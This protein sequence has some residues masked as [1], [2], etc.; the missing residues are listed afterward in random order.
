MLTK[1]LVCR[2]CRQSNALGTPRCTACGTQLSQSEITVTSIPADTTVTSVPAD[3]EHTVTSIPVDGTAAWPKATRF[4]IAAVSMGSMLVEG[5]VV[6]ERYEILKLL[7]EGGMGAVYKAHDRELDRVVSLKVI[8]PEL[9][10]HPSILQ[11]FKQEIVLARKITHRN[12]IRIFDLG[13]ATGLRFITMEF[14]EG[15]DLSAILDERKKY[16][17]EEAV[18]ILRQI[19]AALE[20][21]HAEGVVHR[22]LKPQ[23]IMIEA[24][25]R[26]CVMDFGLARSLEAGGFTQV[27]AIMGTPTYMSPEQAKGEA[28]DERSDLF[29]LGLIAYQLLIGK[30]P[31]KGDTPLSSMLL[32]TQ[33]PP[34][35]PIEIDP[36][37]PQQLSDIVMK[38]IAIPLGDRY[39][40]A[41]ELQRDLQEWQE[42]RLSRT[43][44]MPPAPPEKP[45]L[46]VKKWLGLGAAA[47]VLLGIGVFGGNWFSGGSAPPAPTTP[48]T[49]IISDFNNHTGD[50]VFAG[51]LEST[52]KLALEG[53]SFISAYDRSRIRELGIPA[54]DGSLDA[55][56]AQAIAAAQGLN[57]VVTGSL[58]KS[59]AD[60][61]LSLRAIQTV[62]GKVI[63]QAEE[64]ASGKDQVLFAVTKLGAAVR[65]AMGD[66]TSESAQRLS[67]ETL[68]ATSLEAVHE[69]SEGLDMLSVG[70]FAEAQGHLTRAVDLDPN[71]GMAYTIMA[72]AA[73]NQ[74]RF[75][76]AE[77][78]MKEAL[79]RIDRMTER[80]RYRTRAYTYLLSGDH[81]KC[82]EEYSA[83]LARYPAD[84]GAYTNI[85]VCLVHQHN[86][87]KAL[88]YSR[89]AVSILPK[90]AIYHANLA[91]NLAYTGN[92]A[93]AAKESDQTIA[94]G[95]RTG[96]LIKAFVSL[97][98]DRPDAAAEAYR[99]LQAALPSDAAT[100][101]ADLA[102]YQGRYSEA[103]TILT[104]GLAEDKAGA[105]PDADAAATKAWMLASAYTSMGNREAALSAAKQSIELNK[106]VQTRLVAGQVFAH[107]GDSAQATALAE[108][109][110]A[111][112]QVE[113]QTYAKLILG[114]VALAKGNASAAAQRF[115]EAN[116]L[117][118]TWLGHFSLGLAYVAAEKFLEADSE[119]DRC[120]QRRGE[121]LALF[122]DL[123]TFGFFPPVY[124]YQ[125]R[126]R[127]GLKTAGFADSYEKYLAIRGAAGQDP[128]ATEA[129]RRAGK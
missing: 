74:G 105:N 18:P 124:Y 120:I 110:A 82:V 84:T 3:S 21:A 121:A 59:G 31:F 70:K 76:D 129:R 86:V 1:A 65:K 100:G 103:V 29:S 49:V 64:K 71:F 111:E 53:A 94:L 104:K 112:S 11:R 119:F 47:V 44:L 101:L 22:D 38:A 33:G 95:Y 20:A 125:G 99:N 41:A 62:T 24:S 109:L 89:K 30:V 9:A 61:D 96:Y 91:M 66:S 36:S 26:A 77:A 67:M 43:I 83:L 14:V 27:G 51:T 2:K 80:E 118:D 122:L 32:R 45:K 34:P 50:T 56:K 127:E 98:Q 19:C 107:F 8:R 102:M 92:F 46:N 117:L 55:V 78:H 40:T 93:E 116:G 48:M 58:D 115:T 90:R 28:A 17:P 57:V 25:G 79:K 23:N 39:Q 15:D 108:G 85:A 87:A 113:A 5:G 75:Q 69:Y 7:G 12:I 128:L 72:S 68:S 10:G 42:G 106:A 126:A 60:Y 35:A 13:L 37:I 88:E 6:A 4:D 16:P 63:A 54:V 123:P 114:E 73:R 52:L 81:Q 97:G